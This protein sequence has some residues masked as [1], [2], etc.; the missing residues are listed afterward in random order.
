MEKFSRCRWI[1][2]LVVGLP[3]IW[4]SHFLKEFIG[5]LMC[6][7]IQNI[8]YAFNSS[9]CSKLLRATHVVWGETDV[10]LEI[11]WSISIS[12]LYMIALLLHCTLTWLLDGQMPLRSMKL[13]Q[14][15][16]IP[17]FK[18]DVSEV[19]AALV[20]WSLCGATPLAFSI[21]PRLM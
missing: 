2:S 10:L 12:F 6:R 20:S 5:K 11:K 9:R 16:C 1:N 13:M 14:V 19:G 21:W 4:P 3:A 7:W 15:H 8:G 18:S 17:W